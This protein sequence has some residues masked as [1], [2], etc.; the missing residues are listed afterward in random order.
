MG[1][2]CKGKKNPVIDELAY[3]ELIKIGVIDNGKLSTNQKNLLYDYYNKIEG[4]EQVL[5]TCGNC[6][7]AFI[8]EKLSE[9]WKRKSLENLQS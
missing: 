4:V 1:C 9:L 7:D 2:N 6:W 8:K 5:Y 3:L